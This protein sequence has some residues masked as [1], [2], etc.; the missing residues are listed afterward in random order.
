MG[1]EETASFPQPST[2]SKTAAI[3]VLKARGIAFA[4]SPDR[5]PYALTRC[6]GLPPVC[7][8]SQASI[9][10]KFPAEV[11]P[12]PDLWPKKAKEWPPKASSTADR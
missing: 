3:E 4:T 2:F 8:R 12:R 7:R 11:R 1:E 5:Q 10:G 6:A 9:P